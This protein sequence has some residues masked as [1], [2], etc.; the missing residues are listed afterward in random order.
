[1]SDALRTV[2]ARRLLDKY[3]SE[4]NSLKLARPEL[5]VSRDPGPPA[6]ES[7][8]PEL[9]EIATLGLEAADDLRQ[10]R[11]GLMETRAR[12]EDDLAALK[13]LAGLVP[14]GA[15]AP[16]QCLA[17]DLPAQAGRPE[18]PA[19]SPGPAAAEKVTDG[20]PAGFAP[21]GA[22][23]RSGFAWRLAV[24]AA[25][26]TA[27]A[28]FLY[29]SFS[30]PSRYGF[31]LPATAATGLCLDG[32]GARA[33]FADPRRRLLLTVSIT[34]RRVEAQQPFEAEGLKALAFDDT[35][36]WATDGAAIYAYPLGSAYPSGSGYKAGPGIYA[37]SWS[38]GSLWA[39][40]SGNR[41][42]RY[43]AGEGLLQEAVFRLPESAG[44]WVAVSGEKLWSLDAEKGVLSAYTISASPE[45]AGSETVALP[46]APVA[47]FAVRGNA[48][49]VVT[50]DPAEM[51]RLDLAGFG[52]HADGK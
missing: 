8:L 42:V 10:A 39:A 29:S 26:I 27:S 25:F 6:R 46:L 28:L 33:F 41:L 38:G 52:A 2:K 21:A 14:G 19:V 9:Q 47:G 36:F 45:P 43:S 49:W 31:P 17:P 34:G 37:L 50:Q 12:L 13:P 32:P 18:A 22:S 24:A 15:Q 11:R 30:R 35:R 3:A 5:P 16:E 44:R 4:L 51:V 7:R 20:E 48:A 40:S 23:G 1:M